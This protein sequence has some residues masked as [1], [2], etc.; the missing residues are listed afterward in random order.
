MKQSNIWLSFIFKLKVKMI[1]I[2]LILQLKTAD[3]D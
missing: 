2:F 3:I 1:Y